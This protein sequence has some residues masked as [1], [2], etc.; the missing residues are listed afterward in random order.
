[1]NGFCL[2]FDNLVTHIRINAVFW[3]LVG[4]MDGWIS[5]I[6]DGVLESGGSISSALHSSHAL[7]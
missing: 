1:M 4:W 3:W 7:S 2:S 5:T 6:N